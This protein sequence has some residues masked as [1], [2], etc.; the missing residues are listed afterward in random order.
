MCLI[1]AVTGHVD[2]PEKHMSGNA[3]N[4]DLTQQNHAH[5]RL[6]LIRGCTGRNNAKQLWE[7]VFRGHHF[8]CV[9]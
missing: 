6:E 4:R 9:Q 2:R 8:K 5:F 3:T 1:N 7:V